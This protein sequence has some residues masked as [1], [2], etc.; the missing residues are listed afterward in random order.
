MAN[1]FKAAGVPKAF[2]NSILS[3]SDSRNWFSA[4]ICATADK[5]VTAAPK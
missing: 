4:S 5:Q 1:A 2:F 3:A